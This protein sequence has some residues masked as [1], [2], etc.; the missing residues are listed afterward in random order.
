MP[1]KSGNRP[2]ISQSRG[3]LRPLRGA[4][5]GR[6]PLPQTFA[7]VACRRLQ[8]VPTIFSAPIVVDHYA[9]GSRTYSGHIH[10][11]EHTNLLST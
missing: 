2:I 3:I 8:V 7:H 1:E 9:C 10:D 4:K 5:R 6:V 11:P